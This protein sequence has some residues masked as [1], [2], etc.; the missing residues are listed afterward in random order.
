MAKGILRHLSLKADDL[1]RELAY[2]PKTGK[3]TWLKVKYP[4]KRQAGSKSGR[5]WV[6]GFRGVEYKAHRLAFL[7]MTGKWPQHYVDH[8]DRNPL[9]N[10]WSNLRDVTHSVNCRNRKLQWNNTSGQAGVQKHNDRELWVVMLASKYVCCFKSKKKAVEMAR[11][12]RR[13]W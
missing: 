3:F 7:L 1:R 12:L 6:I 2:N 4:R 11:R 10:K 8:I 13:D 5:H 9:N